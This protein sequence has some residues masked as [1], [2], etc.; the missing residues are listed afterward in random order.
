MA[1][2]TSASRP[3]G[4]R[5][6]LERVETRSWGSL[7]EFALRARVDAL[8]RPDGSR[9]RRKDIA[10]E[11]GWQPQSL[12]GRMRATFIQQHVDATATTVARLQSYLQAHEPDTPLPGSDLVT[13]VQRMR[14]HGSPSPVVV[15]STFFTALAAHP[16]RGAEDVIL[17][18]RALAAI[19]ARA[20]SWRKSSW[21]YA[22][23]NGD[24]PGTGGPV[25][26]TISDLVSLLTVPHRLSPLLV[27][28]AGDLRDWVVPELERTLLESPVGWRAA[29]VI[30]PL[31][32]NLDIAGEGSEHD[33]FIDKQREQLHDLL[34][35][36]VGSRA[37]R[38]L[39]PA[40]GFL[41]EALRSSPSSGRG[42][43]KTWPDEW[44]FAR[45]HLHEVA[46]DVTAPPRQRG[47][48]LWCLA[49]RSDSARLARELA[50]AMAA[51]TGGDPAHPLTRI[52][53]VVEAV[54]RNRSGRHT[55]NVDQWMHRVVEGWLESADPP[56]AV[57]RTVLQPTEQLVS[58][59]VM[60]ID[61][62]QRRVLCDTL[63]AAGLTPSVAGFLATL[64]ADGKAPR[65][66]RD[67]ATVVAGYLGH[68]DSMAALAAVSA[69]EDLTLAHAAT[70]AMGSLD[71][72]PT[73]SV[74]G[75]LLDHVAGDDARLGSA[76]AYALAS[77]ARQDLDTK[78]RRRLAKTLQGRLDR[79]P[80]PDERTAVVEWAVR[81][82]A[83]GG[84]VPPPG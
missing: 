79:R 64:I 65:L 41:E 81:W 62:G 17:T 80:A 53:G 56:H 12:S 18:A 19:R 29:R 75:L 37:R 83:D 1:S 30:P 6:T 76:A 14:D 26:E 78:D 71:T 59:A 84:A 3:G 28:A 38:T 13:F 70:M 69:G 32:R 67:H 42:R 54:L 61:T 45:D 47:F 48:A 23:V 60:S 24:D 63:M 5:T 40:R 72:D 55:D 77:R 7:V 68:G 20:S 4:R 22:K 46:A 82:L 34:S 35:T 10:E 2:N 31:H 27:E 25:D 43:E 44:G 15:P 8:R 16:P 49:E 74:A 50:P 21:L 66:L 39:D 73:G 11:C 51:E 57:P 58:S 36:V 33:D 9:M 52:T